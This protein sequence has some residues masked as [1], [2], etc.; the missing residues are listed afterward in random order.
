MKIFNDPRTERDIALNINGFMV[1]KPL[2]WEGKIDPEIAKLVF[3]NWELLMKFSNHRVK[4]QKFPATLK[5]KL[6]GILPFT[7]VFQK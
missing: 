3:G 2:S 5:M 1:G 4:L 6:L 7:K